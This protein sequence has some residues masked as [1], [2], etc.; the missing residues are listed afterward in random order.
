MNLHALKGPLGGKSPQVPKQIWA[1]GGGKG[2]IGK[3]LITT[4][5]GIHLSWRGYRVVLIDMDLGGANA[6]TVLGVN[7]PTHSLGDLAN[8][9]IQNARDLIMPTPVRNLSLI[10]GAADPSGIANLPTLQKA[11]MIRKFKE[12]EADFILLDLGAGT[13]YNT[14]DFFLMADTKVIAVTPEP[15]A[16]ENV[17]RFIKASFYRMLR[18]STSS[19]YIRQ[20]IETAVDQKSSE[21]IR[22]PRDLIREVYRLSP[23]DGEILAKKLHEFNLA[24]IVNQVR[25]HAE[26]DI[27]PSIQTVCRQYFG[28]SVDYMGYL[29]YDN[30]VWQA[31]RKRIPVLLDAPNSPI[32]THFETIVR[33]LLRTSRKE[34]NHG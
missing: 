15:T 32:A 18:S 4:S 19:P 9:K 8:G 21:A 26:S 16:I 1:I 22:S 28:I 10:S 27:G 29:P 17:Y 33:N 5:M 13:T 7:P 2:G 31:I 11:R 25:L 14:L 20:L 34:A 30:S 23:A 24:L 6:H 12:L 3:T